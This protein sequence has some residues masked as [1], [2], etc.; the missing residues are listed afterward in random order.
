VACSIFEMDDSYI[1]QSPPKAVIDGE[2][3]QTRTIKAVV[4][5]SIDLLSIVEIEEVDGY[6]ALQIKLDLLWQDI[7][8]FISYF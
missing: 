2:T 1:K 7:L 5:V 8:N 4:N 3:V 6:I